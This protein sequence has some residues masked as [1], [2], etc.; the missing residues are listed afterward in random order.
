M[1]SHVTLRFASDKWKHV[2]EDEEKGSIPTIDMNKEE[3]R[4]ANRL[5][6][7]KRQSRLRDLLQSEKKE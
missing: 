7:E 2:D 3:L 5:F 6:L 1:K 4:L